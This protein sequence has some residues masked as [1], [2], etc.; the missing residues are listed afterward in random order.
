MSVQL[1]ERQEAAGITE[2]RLDTFE[3]LYELKTA[4]GSL[5]LENISSDDPNTETLERVYDLRNMIQNDVVAIM[6]GELKPEYPVVYPVSE[7]AIV[8]NALKLSH[9]KQE[10]NGR[11][12]P[13]PAYEWLFNPAATHEADAFARQRYPVDLELDINTVQHIHA[14]ILK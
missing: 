2:V 8:V 7:E 6:T 4:L 14:A 3:D 10:A 11:T 1:L 13:D 5:A 12:E 9:A